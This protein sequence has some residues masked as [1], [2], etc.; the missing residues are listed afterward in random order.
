MCLKV[1]Y[2]VLLEQDKY[3]KA[4]LTALPLQLYWPP[5]YGDTLLEKR[6]LYYSLTLYGCASLSFL[7]SYGNLCSY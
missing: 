1:K 7:N 5:Q 6:D 2:V 3:P 4:T